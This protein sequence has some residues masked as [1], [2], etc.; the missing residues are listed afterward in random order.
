ME[1]LRACADAGDVER[2]E[3]WLARL[4]RASLPV[5]A[6]AVN[7]VIHSCARAADV[8]R[9]ERWLFDMIDSGIEPDL[10]SFNILLSACAEAADLAAAHRWFLRMTQAGIVADAVTHRTMVTVCA[11]AGNAQ[12]AEE[13]LAKMGDARH[14]LD[15]VSCSSLIAAY[16]TAG[17]APGAEQWLQRMQEEGVPAGRAAFDPVIRAWSAGKAEAAEPKRAEGWLWKALEAGV[18]PTDTALVAVLAAFVRTCDL[19]GA[20]R[21][22][23]V[24]RRLRR[25]PSAPACAVL[26][27]RSAAAGDWAECEALLA[28]L[29]SEGGRP[30][31]ACL[32]AL[33]AA[34]A[35]APRP[36]EDGRAEEAFRELLAAEGAGA[37]GGG[38][39]LGDLRRALGRQRYAALAGELRLPA[40]P[41]IR[42][43]AH[44][45]GRAVG[46]G[47]AALEPCAPEGG[48]G[49]AAVRSGRWQ[50]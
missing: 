31:G 40:A 37:G 48:G 2:T 13:W 21:I 15:E 14:P 39:V 19:E 18:E 25:W 4:V 12:L 29:R 17:D 41:A 38:E 45:R 5:T 35:R 8:P 33:L 34:Y 49:R 44:A 50:S 46:A 24:M 1:L 3:A 16:A 6:R 23:A 32:R 7:A 43:A 26:A 28:E 47:P 30:D 27:R 9:A 11:R 36:P 20:D 10:F 42:R 22:V